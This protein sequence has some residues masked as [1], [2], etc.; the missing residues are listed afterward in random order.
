MT[1]GEAIKRYYRNYVNFSGRARRSEFW[2]SVLFIFLVNTGINFISMLFWGSRAILGFIYVLSTVWSLANIIPSLSISVRRLHDT[3]KPGWLLAVFYGIP[4]IM[5]AV[6]IVL[7]GGTVMAAMSGSEKAVLTF[8]GAFLIVWVIML[9]V[10]LGLGI[11]LLVF[12]CLD[13]DH[14]PNKYGPDPKADEYFG[15]YGQGGYIGYD[16]VPYNNGGYNNGGQVNGDY[17]NGGY[18]N[19]GYGN[20]GNNYGGYGNG[21]YGKG[22]LNNGGQGNAG[23]D[24]R[25]SGNAGRNIS[26]PAGTR[27]GTEGHGKDEKDNGMS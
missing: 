14:G 25:G 23:Y 2:Y 10:C 7:A 6:F 22:D 12:F 9:L 21:S 5:I 18:N 1:F 19:G 16:D 27:S 26:G 20:G 24:N 8:T 15:Y 3:G 13:G 11:T 17:G 4:L